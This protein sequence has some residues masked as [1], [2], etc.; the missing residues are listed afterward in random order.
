MSPEVQEQKLIKALETFHLKLDKHLQKYDAKV[1]KASKFDDKK[2]N[3]QKAEKIEKAPKSDDK[4]KPEKTKPSLTVPPT[5]STATGAYK[6]L[7]SFI[8][9]PFG[10][11][12]ESSKF[13]AIIRCQQK[14][15]AWIDVLGKLAEK[16]NIQLGES[17]AGDRSIQVEYGGD[18]GKHLNLESPFLNTLDSICFECPGLFI[19]TSGRVS[20]WKTVGSFLGLFSYEDAPL[21]GITH[22][23]LCLAEDLIEGRVAK[24]HVLR[25]MSQRLSADDFLAQLKV[26]SLSDYVLQ[27]FFLGNETYLPNNVELWTKRF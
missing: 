6:G 12:E 27:S 2:T 24:E 23:W 3:K 25:K 21:S 18:S 8:E 22:H 10:Y 1:E 9:N 4:T 16:K 13:Q 7:D 15:K 20:V 26:P 19:S 14:D 11:K 5:K 17:V